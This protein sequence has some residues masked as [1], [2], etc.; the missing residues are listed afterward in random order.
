VRLVL[1]TGKGGVGKTTT[2]AATAAWAAR[3]GTRT[4]V[5]STD[6]AHSLGDV[7]GIELG[8]DP[9][10]IA[11]ALDAVEIDARTEMDRHW[12]RIR[13]Y[14]ASL[15]RYQGIEEIV[16]EELALL[17]GA[18]ELSTLLGV[19]AQLRTGDYDLVVLDC[20]PTGAALR[21]TTLPDVAHGALRVLLRL[22]G[23]L[24][25]VVTPVAREVVPVPLPDRHVF[26]DADRLLYRRLRELRRRLLDTG[27]TVRLVLTP[28]R[29]TIDEARRAWTDLC[30]FDLA[31]DAVV[32][33]RMLPEAA[34]SE[35]FFRDWG[36]VQ[37]ER[38]REVE[39]QFAPL[40]VLV[41]PLQEDEVTG[42]ERLGEHGA[43]LFAGRTPEAVLVRPPRV[44]F[45]REGPGVYTVSLPLPHARR[46]ELDVAKVEEDLVVRAG[47]L[48]RCLP[49]PRRLADLDLLGARLHEGR[50]VV[51]LGPRRESAREADPDAGADG[52]P[53]RAG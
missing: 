46:E 28:E 1:Y 41:A 43:A 52:A 38:R 5:A 30:L 39:A 12:G 18:E 53:P 33:N 8:P 37:E 49:L 45:V 7:L 10:R 50:L 20:A 6:A 19:E 44:R 21:L 2:A 14:L 35:E 11:P 9:Q 31:C 22:Q 17:P 32:L 3:S 47:P 4:L 36:R 42:L 34:V 25:A 51:R 13:D 27:T 16:A 15:F 24:A 48:R 23:A 40:P 26:R 29:M